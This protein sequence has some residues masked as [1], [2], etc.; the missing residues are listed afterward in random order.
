MSGNKKPAPN[1]HLG[2]VHWYTC[3]VFG[4]HLWVCQGIL[5]LG[6]PK[7]KDENF[8]N[9]EKYS[10]EDL[11]E[12]FSYTKLPNGML[13][14]TLF[15]D[16][17]ESCVLCDI[18]TTIPYD[19]YEE[20]LT[21]QVLF[22]LIADFKEHVRSLPLAK[23]GDGALI[24]NPNDPRFYEESNQAWLKSVIE[25]DLVFGAMFEMATEKLQGEGVAITISRDT[26]DEDD[27]VF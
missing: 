13:R 16:E 19:T 7:M 17:Y 26:V 1:T 24:T 6:N 22:N 10:A 14:L 27:I 18:E 5:G 20:E 3:M 4:T 25:M 11:S 9:T 2:E 15:M 8:L 12:F 23:S 21:D